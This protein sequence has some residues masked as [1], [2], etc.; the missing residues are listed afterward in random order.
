MR[1]SWG[2]V[3]AWRVYGQWSSCGPQDAAQLE[4]SQPQSVGPCVRGF[5]REEL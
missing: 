5:I 2:Y 1:I 4:T 3:L